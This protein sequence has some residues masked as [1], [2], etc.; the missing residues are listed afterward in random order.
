MS[1]GDESDAESMSTDMLEGIC[2]R[3]QSHIIINKRYARHKIRDCI[4]QRR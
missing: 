2:D 3:S 1:S 4:K